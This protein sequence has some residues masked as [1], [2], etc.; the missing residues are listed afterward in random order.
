MMSKPVKK[1]QRASSM[2]YP[3]PVKKRAYTAVAE[4]W[5]GHDENS[6]KLSRFHRTLADIVLECMGLIKNDGTID[7][8]KIEEM[9]ERNRV[10]QNRPTAE[11]DNDVVKQF[12]ERLSKAA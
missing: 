12:I 7:L 8:K 2:Y 10:Q 4:S 1:K 3:D 6:G 11:V 5:F 9:E